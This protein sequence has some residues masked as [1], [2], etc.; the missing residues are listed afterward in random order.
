MSVAPLGSRIVMDLGGDAG[1]ESAAVLVVTIW[2]LG[3]A[4]GPLLIG[5]LSEM[6]GRSPVFN[7]CNVLFVAATLVAALAPST[8]AFV[9]ARALTGAAVA[10][11]VLAP[12]VVDDLFAPE[13]RGFAISLMTLAPLVGGSAGPAL[14]S[15]IAHSH[16]WR[17]VVCISLSAAVVCEVL[18]LTCFR[19]TYQAPGRPTGARNETGDGSVRAAKETDVGKRSARLWLSLVRPV[20]VLLC[21]GVLA[22]LSLFGSVVYAYFYIVSVTLPSVLEQVYGLSPAATESAFLANSESVSSWSRCGR[23]G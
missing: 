22:A 5:P 16:G 21:S 2:E 19:E 4:A 7:G 14:S 1:T 10:T 9:T 12:A 23:R 6:F 11:N 15:V 20:V 3:E 17:A 18:F 8:P 13:Q